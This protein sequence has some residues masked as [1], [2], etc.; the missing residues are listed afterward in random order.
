MKS[1]LSR[2]KTLSMVAI[3]G[4]LFFTQFARAT[5]IIDI[6]N[7]VSYELSSTFTPVS[8]NTYDVFLDIDASAFSHGSGVLSSVALQF[9]KPTF[10]KREEAPGDINDWSFTA[11]GINSG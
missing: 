8:D 9:E 11:G 5:P 3:V 2:I 4:A 7:N 6:T 1:N 10:I